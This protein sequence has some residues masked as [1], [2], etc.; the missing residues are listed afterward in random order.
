MAIHGLEHTVADV[1]EG[2]VDVLEEAGIGLELL[3]E[4]VGDLVGVAVQHPDPGDIGLLGD[5]MD[6]LGQGVAAVEVLAVAGGVLCHQGQLL[7]AQGVHILGLGDHVLH[8]AGAELA[9]NGGD[10]AVGAAV[11]TALGDL[12]VGGVVGGG[13]DA[14]AAQADGILVLEGAVLLFGG[15]ILTLALLLH[16]PDGLHDVVDT[17]HAEKSIYLG[18]LLEDLLAVALGETARDDDALEGAVLLEPG[19]VQDVVDGLLLGA[20]DEGASV[21]DDDVRVD[22]LRGQLVACGH[23]LVEHDL[24]VQ[25]VLGTAEGDESDLHIWFPFVGEVPIH[26]SYMI[27]QKW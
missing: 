26:S 18:E 15:D 9:S 11:V 2:E 24:G 13:E 17:A 20:L 21:D 10:G 5:L 19:L 27:P 4:L 3:D 6:Q 14:V 7:D 1:L 12:E 23:H 22:I 16:G 8:G 25:L